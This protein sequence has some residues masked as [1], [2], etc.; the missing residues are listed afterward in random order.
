MGEKKIKLFNI[1]GRQQEDVMLEHQGGKPPD[2]PGIPGVSFGYV[3]E[4]RSK[5]PTVGFGLEEF[6]KQLIDAGIVFEFSFQNV[7]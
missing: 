6:L 1:V 7:E 2:V 3:K 5:T 4:L